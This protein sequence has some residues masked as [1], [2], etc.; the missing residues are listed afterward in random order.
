M[1]FE[2]KVFNENEAEDC[3][4]LVVVMLTKCTLDSMKSLRDQVVGITSDPFVIVHELSV[5]SMGDVEWTDS[6]RGIYRVKDVLLHI[7]KDSFYWSGYLDSAVR[8]ET[9]RMY[10]EEGG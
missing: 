5:S 10:F 7:D 3:P 1:K 2:L 6:D 4:S 8:I 9:A